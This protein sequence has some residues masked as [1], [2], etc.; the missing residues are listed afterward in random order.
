MEKA[1]GSSQ[2][3]SKANGN[4]LRIKELQ[5]GAI[6]GQAAADRQ[7]RMGRAEG[8][9]PK[10]R[11][12]TSVPRFSASSQETGGNRET[13]A[14]A[15]VSSASGKPDPFLNWR[16]ARWEADSPARRARQP[17]KSHAEGDLQSLPSLSS[18][19]RAVG[20][21]PMQCYH[22][23]VWPYETHSKGAVKMGIPVT[24]TLSQG[25]LKSLGR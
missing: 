10:P 15:A 21:H 24:T 6:S 11:R 17:S 23:S 22:I 2:G 3:W 25:Y 9:P 5:I 13:K 14:R 16:G 8:P 20:L 12:P 19:P 1:G 7:S 18:T 4:R